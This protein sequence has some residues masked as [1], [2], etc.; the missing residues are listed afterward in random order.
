M[1]KGKII[2]SILLIIFAGIFVFSGYK[3]VSQLLE[4]KKAEDLYSDFQNI[5]IT[6]ET[7]TVSSENKEE[8][9]TE[10][11]KNENKLN[12]KINFDA[13]NKK[14]KDIVGW[15]YSPDTPINYPVVKGKDNEQYIRHLPNG[16]YNYAG[17]IF[18]DYRNKENNNDSN[19]IIYGHNMKNDTMFGTLTEYYNQ[20]YYDKHPIIYLLTP[21]KNYEIQLYS[22]YVA[23]A[24]SYA[25]TIN[26]PIDETEMYM[27]KI[28]RESTFKSN[29]K[30]TPGDRTVTLST[31][32][33]VSDEE[34]YVLVGILKE[35]K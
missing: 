17:S 12:L 27:N 33:N 35:I 3:I 29:V 9:N 6:S 18:A 32:T 4:E 1:K 26:R 8:T 28:S 15:I 13:L 14:S 11:E 10:P 23:P 30:Y 5:A 7:E 22:G 20:K 31:C 16:K 21:E 19:Y 34:R 25:Y 24:D 2:R